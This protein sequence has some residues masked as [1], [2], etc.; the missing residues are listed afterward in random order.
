MSEEQGIVVT[1]IKMRFSSMVIFLVKLSIASIPAAII[2]FLIGL[3]LMMLF[4]GFMGGF[5]PHP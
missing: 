5:M 3:L 1:D 2:L 4:G